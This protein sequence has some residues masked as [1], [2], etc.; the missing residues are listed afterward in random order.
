MAQKF[1]VTFEQV[2]LHTRGTELTADKLNI[3]G[4]GKPRTDKNGKLIAVDVDRLVSI[5][6]IEP[7][8]NAPTL[9]E[10]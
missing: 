8:Y 5:G 9:A 7:V 10:V 6:A 1:R 2:G 4:S 3:D